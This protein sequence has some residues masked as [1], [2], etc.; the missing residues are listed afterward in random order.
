MLL[1][2]F[3]AW[4]RRC[5]DNKLHYVSLWKKNWPQ[6]ILIKYEDTISSCTI[7]FMTLHIKGNKLNIKIIRILLLAK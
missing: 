7:N 5:L 3:S 1:D 4:K 2:K 6:V